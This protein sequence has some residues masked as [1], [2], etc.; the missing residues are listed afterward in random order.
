MRTQ[1]DLGVDG[2]IMHCGTPAGLAP[3]I[4]AYLDR[5]RAVRRRAEKARTTTGVERAEARDFDRSHSHRPCP[6]RHRGL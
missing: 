4:G 6:A 5:W 2:V 3:A 1:F